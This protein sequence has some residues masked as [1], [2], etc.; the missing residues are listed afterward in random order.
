[1]TP[2]ACPNHNEL[3]QAYLRGLCRQCYNLLAQRVAR[4]LTTWEEIERQGLVA[5]R[6]VGG[7]PRKIL[8]P[9]R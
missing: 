7:R 3:R 9:V 2:R 6:Q 5:P 1:M 8:K 4:Q